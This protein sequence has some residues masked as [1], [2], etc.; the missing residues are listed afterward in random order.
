[1][2]LFLSLSWPGRQPALGRRDCFDLVSQL[3]D[4]AFPLPCR[5]KGFDP[6]L[7][8]KNLFM[9]KVHFQTNTKINCMCPQI[10]I[11]LSLVHRKKNFG[12]VSR[13][14]TS[15]RTP[16]LSL[17]KAIRTLSLSKQITHDCHPFLRTMLSTWNSYRIKLAPNIF[18]LST[19]LSH[20]WFGPDNK[21]YIIFLRSVQFRH[22]IDILHKGLLL[23]K[24]KLEE[25][26]GSI[27]PCF[28]YLQIHS[29]YW[30]SINNISKLWYLKDFKKLAV[31]NSAV[32]KD[33][34]AAN[35]K[36]FL[37]LTMPV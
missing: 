2:I 3:L 35:Y 14:D 33:L 8:K 26:M 19:F 16:V 27:I 1:M 4:M 7:K 17:H 23:E 11:L 15:R 24:T 32:N 34:L 36:I 13:T 10:W 21:T 31:L 5:Q 9:C 18:L 20:L 29:M 28:H 37:K 22:L 12:K 30:S 25:R 6:I